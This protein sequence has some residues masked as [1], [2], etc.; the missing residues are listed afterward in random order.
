MRSAAHA[1]HAFARRQTPSCEAC[2]LTSTLVSPL[3][4][5]KRSTQFKIDAP[6]HVLATPRP[7]TTKPTPCVP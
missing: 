7:R 5:G 2:R 6:E 4:C 3:R 1:T